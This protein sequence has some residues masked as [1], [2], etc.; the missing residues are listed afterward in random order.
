VTFDGD[1]LVVRMEL[2]LEHEEPKARAAAG[3][4]PAD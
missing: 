3:L 2:Y 1:D 4:R